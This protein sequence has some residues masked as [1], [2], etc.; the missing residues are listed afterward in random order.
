MISEPYD[1]SKFQDALLDYL[2]GGRP[3][4]P[5]LEDL[6][7]AQRQAAKSFVQSVAAARGIDPY[8]SRPSV[9]QLL[10]NLTQTD[11]RAGLLHE[12][13][14]NRLRRAVDVRALVTADTASA[15]AGLASILV[16]QARGM[17]IR[18]VPE[19]KSEDLATAF[20]R[21]AGDVSEVFSTF[22]D[23]HVVLY[24]TTGER[25]K[26]VIVDR[27]DARRAIETPSGESRAPRLRRP[28]TDAATACEEWLT[29][30]IPDFVP[31]SIDT[32]RTA[33]SEETLNPYDLAV[34]V[35]EEVSKSGSRARIAA[36]R[37]TWGDFG[38][39]EAQRLASIVQEA[40]YGHLSAE[41]YESQLDA[42]V[43]IAG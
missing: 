16:V 41:I 38:V 36:K 42:L 31:L 22:A 29:G 12:T 4:P 7:K 40:Q 43:G 24:V 30:L 3:K 26:G 35:V 14:Q 37:D 9:E 6:P 10:A 34:R 8:A 32:E 39:G 2:E 25:P 20:S 19:Y 27:G 21:R 1:L 33:S 28:I 18:V 13:L 17:R 23:S 11:A 5:R 15:S